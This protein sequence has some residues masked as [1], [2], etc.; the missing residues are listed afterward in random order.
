LLEK[1]FFLKDNQIW[2]WVCLSKEKLTLE[3]KKYDFEYF[4][5]LS[6]EKL[7]I[8]MFKYYFDYF[9]QKK[10]WLYTY[11]NT[12]LSINEKEK[13]EFTHI[14]IW[15]WIYFSKKKLTLDMSKYDFE[16]VCQRKCW[17]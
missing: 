7:T 8:D 4:V 10:S 5:C 17:L 2:L 12:S 13:V 15:H 1:N 9:C 6:K 3:I 11:S 16:Y 14:E